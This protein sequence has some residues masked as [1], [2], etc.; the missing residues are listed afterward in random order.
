MRSEMKQLDVLW[1]MDPLA[2]YRKR[3]GTS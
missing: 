1:R 2:C 3:D